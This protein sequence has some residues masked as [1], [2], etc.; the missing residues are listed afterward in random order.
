MNVTPADREEIKAA[1]EGLE[2]YELLA[3]SDLASLLDGFEK[4]AFVKGEVLI[5]QGKTGEIFY[6]LA[7]GRV[8]IY[9]KRALIDR[10]VTTLGPHSFFGELSLLTNEPRTASVV[11]EEDGVVF[12]LTRETFQ[13]A[14][15]NNP[16]V[17]ALIRKT[18]SERK[19]ATHAIEL[20]EAMGRSLR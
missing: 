13:R 1:L 17:G 14:L 18:A 5:T 7:S 6:I 2:W 8:G 20:G 4:H 19:A 16:Q 3:P 9:L 10:Q 15:V 11:G 12:T